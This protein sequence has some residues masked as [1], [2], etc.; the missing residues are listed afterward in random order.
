M[1]G[2]PQARLYVEIH[3]NSRKKSAGFLEI[4]TV[5]FAASEAERVRCLVNE[6]LLGAQGPGLVAK[7]EGA[8]KIWYRARSTKRFGVLS[9]TARAL[10]FEFPRRYRKAPLRR[11]TVEFLVAA[12]PKIAAALDQQAP[13]TGSCR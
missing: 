13:A 6:A 8:D 7:V 10:H 12:L 3:G 4:A 5:G 2:G 11:H 9:R 1:L